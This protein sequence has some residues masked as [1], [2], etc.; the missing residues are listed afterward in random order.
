MEKI[1]LIG[2]LLS[3][4]TLFLF[5]SCSDDSSSTNPG[6]MNNE[7]EGTAFT[8]SG[9]VASIINSSCALAG[10]HVGGAL[11][12]FRTFSGV[13]AN[14]SNIRSMVSSRNMPPAG[15]GISLSTQEINTIVCWVAN[16]APQ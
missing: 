14:R 16:G 15:S 2:S 11:P 8:Y 1:S 13:F 3:I 5:M 12:D 7:C 4:I 10:C 6:G 9:Q